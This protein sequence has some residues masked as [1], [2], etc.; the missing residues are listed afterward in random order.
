MNRIKM[1][2]IHVYV[3]MYIYMRVCER[4]TQSFP[5]SKDIQRFWDIRT[6][7]FALEKLISLEANIL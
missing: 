4:E 2:E 6:P 5:D 1:V 7:P 3:C